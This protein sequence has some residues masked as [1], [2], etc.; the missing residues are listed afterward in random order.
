[1]DK[2]ASQ[3]SEESFGIISLSEL[4]EISTAIILF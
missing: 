3:N 4:E 1:M 2:L